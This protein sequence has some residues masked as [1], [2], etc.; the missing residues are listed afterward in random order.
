MQQDHAE[1]IALK[2]LG[3]IVG[4]E[5]I[6]T[7]FMGASGAG[8]DD[9]RERAA[10][11]EFLA[12]VLDFLTMDDDW[13]IGFCDDAGLSYDTPMTARGS[14]PGGQQMHWT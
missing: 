14:L 3:W 12:S 7:V 1:A 6:L 8:A 5:E 11:P 9:I 10:D 2:A 4:Q 13:I